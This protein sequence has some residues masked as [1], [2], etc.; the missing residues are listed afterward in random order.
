MSIFSGFKSFFE[1]VG[2]EIETLFGKT[3]TVSQKIL[4][5]V[6]YVA[7]LAEGI[8]ALA[9]PAIL[10]VVTAAVTIAEADLATVSAIAS[11]ASVA[12]GTP[13]AASVLAAMNSLESNLTGLLTD[14][15][16]KNA[17]SF[18]KIEAAVNAILGEVKAVLSSL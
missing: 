18:T 3:A 2:A 12:P 1:K 4:A 9:D 17:S 15:G 7:P 10:P 14:A 8:I 6:K 5:V 13:A 16:V 11:G